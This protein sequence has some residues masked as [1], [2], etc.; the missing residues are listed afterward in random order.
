MRRGVA[1]TARGTSGAIVALDEHALGASTYG[2]YAPPAPATASCRSSRTTPNPPTRFLIMPRTTEPGYA[3]VFFAVHDPRASLCC[4]TWRRTSLLRGGRRAA[5][6]QKF[7]R[8]RV[9]QRCDEKGGTT[10][11]SATTVMREGA[12]RA[13]QQRRASASLAGEATIVRHATD[14]TAA[15][16]GDVAASSGG[17]S[18]PSSARRRRVHPEEARFLG[19]HRQGAAREDER[20]GR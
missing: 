5:A 17:S 19:S 16:D 3:V 10:Q 18:E 14:Q 6:G 1:L 7:R 12:F 11:A 20:E 4:A 9:G 2:D 15:R 13:D 8:L